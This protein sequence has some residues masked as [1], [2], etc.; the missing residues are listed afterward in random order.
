MST[1]YIFTSF[2]GEARDPRVGRCVTSAGAAAT[3]TAAS[4]D[5]G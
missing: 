3:A 4:P 1:T 5:D 2:D